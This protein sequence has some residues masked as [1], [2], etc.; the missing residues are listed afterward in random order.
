MFLCKLGVVFI[1][2]TRDNSDRK[3]SFPLSPYLDNNSLNLFH[4]VNYSPSRPKPVS[5]RLRSQVRRSLLLMLDEYLSEFNYLLEVL[6]LGQKELLATS[7]RILYQSLNYYGNWN[8]IS[9]KVLSKIEHTLGLPLSY[10][11]L[12]VITKCLVGFKSYY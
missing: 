5:V 4:C 10:L 3:V 2:S 11:V 6:I 9:R 7:V 8:E 12:K 1:G